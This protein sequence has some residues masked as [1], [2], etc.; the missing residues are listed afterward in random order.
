M[1]GSAYRSNVAG[2]ALGL[3]LRI[4]SGDALN[5][6]GTGAP[7]LQ[8]FVIVSGTLQRISPH[9]NLGYQWNGSSILAGDPSTGQAADL[10][11]QIVYA[12]GADVGSGRFTVVFDV[13]GRYLLDAERN[14]YQAQ[15][16][17]VA[18]YRDQL[19]SQVAAFKAL[20]GGYAI[21]ETAALALR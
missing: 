21:D 11:D 3:D 13:L 9:F 12:A 20:G 5:L 7:G 6:L 19:N 2:V 15:L 4:P 8:P 1:K 18:A 17:Q 14:W 10:P 16:H